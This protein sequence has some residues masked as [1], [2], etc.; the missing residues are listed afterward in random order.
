MEEVTITRE[1]IRKKILELRQD[2]APG[3]RV[4]P[5]RAHPFKSFHAILNSNYYNLRLIYDLPNGLLEGKRLNF[6]T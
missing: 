1:K 2:S 6:L 3:P 5:Y 4:Q